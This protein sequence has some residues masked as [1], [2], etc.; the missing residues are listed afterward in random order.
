MVQFE[1]DVEAGLLRLVKAGSGF[2]LI[3]CAHRAK[4]A[5]FSHRSPLKPP[6]DNSRSAG[7]ATLEDE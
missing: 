4:D 1:T 7:I 5:V 2:N 3:Q 6:R